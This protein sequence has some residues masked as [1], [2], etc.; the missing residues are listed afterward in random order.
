MLRFALTTVALLAFIC[1]P[2]RAAMSD[3]TFATKAAIGG[4]AEVA[5]GRLAQIQG[6]NTK[7]LGMKMVQD[8][9]KA[10]AKLAA[11]VRNEGKTPSTSIGTQGQ[12]EMARLKPLHGAAFDSAY[13]KGQ[14]ADHQATI[15]LLQNEIDNGTDPKLKSWATE[16]LPTVKKHLTMF[17]EASG[18]TKT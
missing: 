16:T 3:S 18:S 8:H 2:L 15:A 5:L 11:I 17:Q 14:I 6:S 7:S 12:A 1:T 13:I 10:G 9:S 4:N